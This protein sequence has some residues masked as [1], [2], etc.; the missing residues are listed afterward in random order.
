MYEVYK[1]FLYSSNQ[2]SQFFSHKIERPLAKTKK[3]QPSKGQREFIAPAYPF[4][5]SSSSLIP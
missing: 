2:N 3:I 4:K 5:P 1:N